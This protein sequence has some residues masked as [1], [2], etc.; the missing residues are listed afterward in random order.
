GAAQAVVLVGEAGIGKTRLAHEFADWAAADGADVLR[1]RALE[2]GGRVPYQ[3]LVQ[4]LRARLERANAP[5]DVLSDVWLA[6]LSRLLPELRDRYPDLPLPAADEA[7][8]QPRL[9][10]AVARLGEA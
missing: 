3:P 1:A 9:F 8:A 5:E 10:E 4:A 2:V 6:E 7:T